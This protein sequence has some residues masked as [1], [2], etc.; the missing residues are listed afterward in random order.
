MHTEGRIGGASYSR[1]WQELSGAHFYAG[2]YDS[3]LSSSDNAFSNS[4]RTYPFEDSEVKL[5]LKKLSN[6]RI[7]R[8]RYNEIQHKKN[9][10][11]RHFIYYKPVKIEYILTTKRVSYL[12]FFSHVQWARFVNMGIAAALRLPSRGAYHYADLVSLEGISDIRAHTRE[13]FAAEITL[14]TGL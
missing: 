6:F 5:F 9:A 2:H 8:R 7:S 12:G 10:K 4:S 14:N 11:N 13:F 3:V 1:V